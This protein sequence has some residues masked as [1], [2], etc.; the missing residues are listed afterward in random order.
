MTY[1]KKQVLIVDDSPVDIVVLLEN[2]KDYYAVLVADSGVKALELA[3]KNPNLE[4]ILLDVMMPDMNGYETCEQLKADSATKDIE[5][6]F[7]SAH[8]TTEE[9]IAGFDAGGSD[10]L[11]K[12][13]Q[14]EVLRQKVKLAIE[15]KQARLDASQ[16]AEAQQAAMQ[17]AMTAMNSWGE[18]GILL[19]FF[20]KSFELTT[21][22]ELGHAVVD[23]NINY[24]L[25]N[26]VQ[27]RSK[28]GIVNI[29]S[30]EPISPLEI[31]L[32]T[33]LKDD[34]RIIERNKRAIFNF[35]DISLL[36]KDMPHDEDKRGRLRDHL[37]IL[38]E[39]AE[40]KIKSLEMSQSLSQLAVDSEQALHEIEVKQKDIKETNVKI[41]DKLYE[42]I[43]NAF[44]SLGLIE[45]QEVALLKLV[46]SGINSSLENYEEG[47]ENDE[48]MREIVGRLISIS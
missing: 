44:M 3:K 21:L 11:I 5:V 19:D 24:D 28:L 41:F 18:Q 4:V 2:L 31:E 37:A 20:R 13:V 7:V 12:P 38:L 14:P 33:R 26:S 9:K 1:E 40:A 15:N 17:T 30:K 45:E 39:G 36:I 32:L 16:A 46:Q 29:S 23:A 42:D 27:I 8:D 48:K 43:E 22:H 25:Q 35:G 6:I 10:Y 47:L 34:G